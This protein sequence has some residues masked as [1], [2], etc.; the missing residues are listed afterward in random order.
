MSCTPTGIP[1]TLINGTVT[2][3]ANATRRR[4]VEHEVAGRPRCQRLACNVARPERR[5]TGAGERDR[6]VGQLSYGRVRGVAPL[7]TGEQAGAIVVRRHGFGALQCRLAACALMPSGAASSM[8]RW[9]QRFSQL[10]TP[11][12]TARPFAIACS[13]ASTNG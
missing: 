9:Y 10:V 6:G 3:G 2:T 5:R 7:L 4:R 13:S 1:P 8:P 12:Q 11:L